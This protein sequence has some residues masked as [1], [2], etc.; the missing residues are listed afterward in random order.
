MIRFIIS[1]ILFIT[2]SSLT[3]A[4]K[5][6]Y[7][8]YLDSSQ[9]ECA[10]L[11]VTKITGNQYSYCSYFKNGDKLSRQQEASGEFDKLPVELN[12][13]YD[14]IHFEA[15]GPLG[16]I[17]TQDLTKCDFTTKLLAAHRL[18]KAGGQ[19]TFKIG[20]NLLH[21]SVLDWRKQEK[22]RGAEKVANDIFHFPDNP[23]FFYLPVNGAYGKFSADPNIR[24]Q[25]HQKIFDEFFYPRMMSAKFSRAEY[26]QDEYIN[27]A[28]VIVAT[29]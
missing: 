5:H 18:L 27:H 24:N 23:T 14:R 3:A 15:A 19:F 2:A 28:I 21:D 8:K 26:R 29:K 7:Y 10:S 17:N 20:A 12:G 1:F 16:Q 9:E 22:M 6:P 4:D 11:V 25:A 13:T